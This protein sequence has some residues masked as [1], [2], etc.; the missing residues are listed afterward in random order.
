MFADGAVS[1]KEKVRLVLLV[2]LALVA[3]A[4]NSVLGRLALK[5]VLIEAELFTVLRVTSGALALFVFL[6]VK[7][8]GKQ[9]WRAG[10][11][12]GSLALA[13]YMVAFSWGYLG[14]NTGAGALILFASVQVTMVGWATARGERL[15]SWQG[16]GLIVA[17]AGLAWLLLAPSEL[18]EAG[19]LSLGAGAL[20]A[21]S[22]VA[23]GA[24]TLFGKGAQDP[25]AE[26][27]GN[28]VKATPLVVLVFLAV[29][30]LGKEQSWSARGVLL[31]VASGVVTSAAG[32]AIWYQ[33][34][35]GLTATRAA[36]LQLL[37]P[38][39]AAL[40]G[41]VFGAEPLTMRLI[42]ASLLVLG[43]VALV[44]KGKRGS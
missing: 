7:G 13:L 4:G 5:G 40:G 27:G 11:W 26:T 36:G 41:L 25:L 16:L 19:E 32:Y 43:G 2:V 30:F 38:V 22:G 8:K 9:V 37:V 14:I 35:R 34:L 12:Q 10:S 33:A 24:Y 15:T 23:W 17:L 42:L 29:L 21:L 6:A 31:A 1:R 44:L 18:A 20:M 39:L 3:F 28:F